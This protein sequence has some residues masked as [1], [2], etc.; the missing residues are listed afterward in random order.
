MSTSL[1]QLLAPLNQAVGPWIQMGLANPWLFSPG[2]TVL[3]V[4]GRKTGQVRKV[5]LTCYLAGNLMLVGTVRSNSQ[6]VKNV[7]VADEIHVWLWGQRRA[8]ERVQVTDNT[9]WLRL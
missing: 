1:L 4:P 5:P 6:W 7:D 2:V 8:V 9:A 3:E